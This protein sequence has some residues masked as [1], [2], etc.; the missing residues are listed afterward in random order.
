MT[1][2][3]QPA[4]RQPRIEALDTRDGGAYYRVRAA[5]HETL[6]HSQT[7]PGGIRDAERGIDAL[8]T[9]VFDSEQGQAEFVRR[10][11]AHTTTV[12]LGFDGTHAGELPP[13]VG[14]LMPRIDPSALA[15]GGVTA[16]EDDEPTGGDS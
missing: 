7:Y 13:A 11:K 9:A 6:A 2:A 10:I 14:I 5:N 4:E 16:G 12:I 8:V 15:D 1:D 3:E